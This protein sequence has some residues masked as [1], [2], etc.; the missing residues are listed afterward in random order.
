MEVRIE[1]PIQL[2]DRDSHLEKLRQRPGPA[3][4]QQRL[5]GHLDEEAGVHHILEL[6]ISEAPRRL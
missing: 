4:E 5:S 2:E 1:D 3:V 6:K